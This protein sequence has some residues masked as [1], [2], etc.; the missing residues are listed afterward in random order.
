MLRRIL[1]EANLHTLQTEQTQTLE[2]IERETVIILELQTMAGQDI[3]QKDKDFL[4]FA[5]IFEGL[6]LVL[7]F[8]L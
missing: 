1:G 8:P 3:L 2:R 7:C 4:L 6:G 5:S